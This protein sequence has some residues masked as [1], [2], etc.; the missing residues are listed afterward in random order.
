MI[1]L[2]E[3]VCGSWTHEE[4]NA[5]FLKQVRENSSQEICYIGEKEHICC[6]RNLYAGAR[7]NYNIITKPVPQKDAD[8]YD[9][10]LYYFR[11]MSTIIMKYQP[12]ILIVLC[13]YRPCILAA[14]LISVIFP[15][16]KIK[17]VIHGMIEEQKGHME[18]YAKLFSYS[19]HCKNLCFVTYSPFCTDNYWGLREKKFFFMHLPYI[20]NQKHARKAVPKKSPGKTIIGIIGACANTKALKL[21]SMINKN[22]LDK[23]YEF[24]VISRFGDRFRCLKNVKVLELEFD[25][26][27]KN[28]L[29]QNIDYLLLPYDK[30]EYA[31]SASGVLWDAISNRVP[32]LMLDCKYFEYYMS[33]RIGY[34]AKDINELCKIICEKIQCGKCNEHT[35]FIGLNNIEKKTEEKMKYLLQ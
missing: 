2:L 30:R 5:G 29:L 32:C 23:E 17:F 35:F 3:P 4:V 34:Q 8:A 19:V 9:K 28:K 21:I 6:I 10:T 15:H 14:E 11:L 7:V 20:M 27:N 24:W 26:E 12:D 16:L 31:L 1:V 18:S 22:S 33:Y 13:G 25:R